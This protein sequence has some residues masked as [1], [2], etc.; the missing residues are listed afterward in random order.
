MKVPEG[1]APET[2]KFEF[3][4][5]DNDKDDPMYLTKQVKITVLAFYKPPEVK[6]E[7]PKPI[8]TEAPRIKATKVDQVG[9]L[10]LIFD[11]ELI[12]P[13]RMLNFTSYNEGASYFNVTLEVN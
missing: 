1:F 5:S 2:C 8:I 6:E 4:A 10:R 11:K 3:T 12:F 7:D 13:D 9:N